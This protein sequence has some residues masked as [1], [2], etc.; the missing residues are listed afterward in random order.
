M[1]DPCA[2]KGRAPSTIYYWESIKAENAFQGLYITLF[3]KK[4]GRK[5]GRVRGVKVAQRGD[6]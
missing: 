5:E 2:V 4:F 1:G 3:M 6:P